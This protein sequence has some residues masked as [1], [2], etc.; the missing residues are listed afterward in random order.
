MMNR[1][2]MPT[3]Y[4]LIALLVMLILR[5]SQP[6]D[7]IIPT[8]WN[9]LG[10]VPLLLG[11]VINLFADKALHEANTTV[12]PFQESN[13]LVTGGVYG[14]S[15][16]PMYLGFVMVLIGVAILLGALAPW[17]IVAIFIL[18]LEIVYIQV[19]E[20][21]LSEKFGSSWMDYKRKVRRW[22]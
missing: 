8:P 21:M 6:L 22:M 11:I 15:R 3:T 4:L 2:V 17:A 16:H 13:A 10:I 14:F 12:K 5:F 18:L 20:R 1:K 9:F 19:E 7:Q